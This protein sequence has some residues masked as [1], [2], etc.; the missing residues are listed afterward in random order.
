MTSVGVIQQPKRVAL[1]FGGCVAAVREGWHTFGGLLLTLVGVIQQLERGGG[2]LLTLA[3]VLQTSVRG[4]L[5]LVE[6]S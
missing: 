4:D 6:C 1:D 2:S 5:P 3:G